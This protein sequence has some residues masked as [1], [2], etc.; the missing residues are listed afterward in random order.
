[1]RPSLQQFKESLELAKSLRRIERKYPQNPS[2]KDR[3]AVKALRGGSVVLMVA[4]FE[5][6]LRG[7]FEEH[8]T[9]LNAPPK[10]IDFNKLPDKLKTTSIIDGLQRALKGPQYLSTN[11]IDRLPNIIGTCKKIIDDD[12][13]PDPFAETSSNPDGKTLRGLFRNVGVGDIFAQIKP[14]FEKKWGKSVAQVFI[15]S[16]L[17]EIVKTRHVVAHTTDI[18]RFS[19][20]DEN[21]YLKFLGIL[22]ILLDSELSRHIKTL[23]RDAIL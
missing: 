6:Y 16:K 18:L 14:K 4:A 9:S 1:M 23:K 13:I 3:P 5:Y 17:D 20:R 12:V 15:E 19:R 11:R 8:M 7:L 22:A 10:E 21:A 2:S